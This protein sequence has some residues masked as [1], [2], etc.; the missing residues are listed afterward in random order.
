MKACEDVELREE[1]E[2]QP[3]TI[4]RGEATGRNSRKMSSLILV[5]DLTL[6][7]ASINGGERSAATTINGRNCSRN[8]SEVET[9]L[10]DTE[11]LEAVGWCFKCTAR[12]MQTST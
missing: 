5:A 10:N 11:L 3:K 9:D 4:R 2:A 12:I 1:T 8:G 6:L 7:T